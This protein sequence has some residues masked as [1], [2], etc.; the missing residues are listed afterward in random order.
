MNRTTD[1]EYPLVDCSR[2]GEYVTRQTDFK[3]YDLELDSATTCDYG[4]KF[5][6]L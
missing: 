6:G 4:R 2:K 5:N 3:G 1:T